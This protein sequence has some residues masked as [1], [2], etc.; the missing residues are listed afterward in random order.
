M[1]D[2]KQLD[3]LAKKVAASLPVGLLTMQEEMQKNFRAALAAGIARLDLVTREEFDVQA[4]VLART[5][6]KLELLERRITE[7]EQQSSQR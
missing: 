2:P 4:G 7:L 1:I 6:A 5:R 3:D